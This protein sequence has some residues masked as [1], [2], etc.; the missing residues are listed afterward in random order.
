MQQPAADLDALD[1]ATGAA[2]RIRHTQ[3]RLL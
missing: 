3:M 1:A 2:L